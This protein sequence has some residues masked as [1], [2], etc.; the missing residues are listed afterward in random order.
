MTETE[1]S[2][3]LKSARAERLRRLRSM[4]G[5]NQEN[6]ARACSIG[7]STL[8][9]YE[10][11]IMQ[12]LSEK[13]AIKIIEGVYNIGVQCSL[14]W[15]LY[16]NGELPKLLYLNPDEQDTFEREVTIQSHSIRPRTNVEA[17]E[18]EFDVFYKMHANGVVIQIDDSSMEPKYEIGD[19]VGGNFLL[20]DEI[21]NA[22]NKDCIIKL[23]DEKLIVRHL[24]SSNEADLYNAY[25]LSPTA[26]VKHPPLLNIKVIAAAPIIRVWR[27][28]LR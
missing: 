12:G 25:C 8:K 23:S 27:K 15:L 9:N 3:D 28:E 13:A 24:T 17:I 26:N 21:N 11:A 7:L 18:A 14:D 10:A 1:V 22:I 6:F 4:T 2:T 16:G 19:W 5:L 20:S